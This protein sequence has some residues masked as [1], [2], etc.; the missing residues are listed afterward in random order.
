VFLIDIILQINFFSSSNK[1]YMMYKNRS[2]N[3]LVVYIG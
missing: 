2:R 3:L 1:S